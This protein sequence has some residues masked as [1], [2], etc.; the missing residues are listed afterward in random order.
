MEKIKGWPRN[1]RQFI[2]LSF[3]AA[4]LTVSS[5]CNQ[6]ETANLS[7]SNKANSSKAN[8]LVIGAG[9][10]GLAAA[11]ELQNNGF[12]VTILEGRDRIGGRIYTDRSLG[13]A[14]DLGAS[15]IHGIQNNPIGKLAKDSNIKIL[16]TDYDNG[17]LYSINGRPVN[18][19]QLSQAESLSEDIIEQAKA[20]AER[21]DKDISVAE[22]IKR[23]LKKQQLTAA[24][25]KLVEWQLNS[26]IV[27]ETGTDMSDLSIQEW[28]E[29]EA[30]GG[31]DFLFPNGYDQII[32]ILA[33]NLDIKLK[34]NVQEVNYT[35]SGV[36]VKTNQGSFSA[37]AVVITLPLGILKADKVK[38]SPALPSQKTTAIQRLAM[39]VLNKVVLKF[40]K[41]FWE[42]EYDLIGVMSEEKKDFS[43][44]VNLYKYNSAPILVGLTGGSFAR[45]LESLS[46]KEI[47]EKTMKLLTRIYGKNIPNPEKILRT[48]WSQ[49]KFAFGSYSYVPVGATMAARDALAKPVNKRLFFAGEATS[50]DYPATVHGAFLSGLREAKNIK[51]QL[52]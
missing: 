36:T 10:A 48:Q 17:E 3:L 20:L 21:L 40:P 47:A 8:I 7:T 41:P 24:Q 15:W 18:E 49:D 32:E 51:S 23:V 4:A 13:Y 44:F 31:D 45:S 2:Q 16:R 52:G 34:Q 46:E 28:D 42:K 50:R 30:F 11:R 39:G 29:D 14:I 19:N 27:V 9:I 1:R 43:E 12:K 6:K 22:A 33:K 26:N 25:Q 35:E 5:S 38:F 37:D